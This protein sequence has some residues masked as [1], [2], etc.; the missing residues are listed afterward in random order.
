MQNY[1]VKSPTEALFNLDCQKRTNLFKG[2][3]FVHGQEDKECEMFLKIWELS[4][5]KKNAI[6]N[7]E[8]IVAREIQEQQK[9]LREKIDEMLDILNKNS[10]VRVYITPFGFMKSYD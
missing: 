10:K 9:E 6:E 7:Q 4:I 3:L 2:C 5:Y 8:F 1:K